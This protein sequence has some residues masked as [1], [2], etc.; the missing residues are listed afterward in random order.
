MA[1]GDPQRTVRAAA[2]KRSRVS[3]AHPALKDLEVLVGVWDLEISHARFLPSPTSTVRLEASVEWT[4]GGDFLIMRQGH[5]TVGPPY[6]TWVIGRDDSAD[7]YT[8]LYADD[9]RVARVYHMRFR[10]GVWQ[11]WREVPGF[12]QRFKGT[13]SKDGHTIAASWTL[14]RDDGKHWEHDFDLTYRRTARGPYPR[15]KRSADTT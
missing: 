13:V 9:R 1:T 14:S 12:F 4:E 6:A 8:V 2:R 3:I 5:K 10:G 7:N 11:Q 15:N